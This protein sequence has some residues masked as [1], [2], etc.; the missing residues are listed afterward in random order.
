MAA[1]C[2]GGGAGASLILPKFATGSLML[3][4]EFENYSGF[5]TK[6]SIYL[7]NPEKSLLYQTRINAAAAWRLLPFL[8]GSLVVPLVYNYNSYSQNISTSYGVGD[9]TLN[10]TGELFQ[11]IKCVWRVKSLSDLIPA[12]YLGASL[13]IPTGISPYDNVFQSF[14]ITGKGFYRFDLKALFD[15]TVYPFTLNLSAA[16]GTHLERAV[17]R[18]YGKYIEPYRKKLGNRYS[19]SGALGYSSSFMNSSSLTLSATYGYVEEKGG[20]IDGNVD[21]N[22]GFHKHSFGALIAYSNPTQSLIIKAKYVKN[23]E[24]HRWGKNQP[25]TGTIS[26]EAGYVFW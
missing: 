11:D 19:L 17:N 7:Q 15:K 16:A 4:S 3:S 8:Q 25:A 22:S 21:P 1:S 18:E 26:M 12:A 5:Y 10:F 24:V 20:E 14:D 9:T 6:E 2:C 13:V 23:P